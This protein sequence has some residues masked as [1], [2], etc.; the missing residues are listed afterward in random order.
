[1]ELGSELELELELGSEKAMELGSEL[2][3][4]KVLE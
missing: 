3:Q 4:L 1:M 2:V